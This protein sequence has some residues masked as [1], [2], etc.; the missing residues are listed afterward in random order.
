M[1][2]GGIRV[3]LSAVIFDRSSGSSKP[4]SHCGRNSAR[5]PILVRS[6]L[7]S[8]DSSLGCRKATIW[9]RPRVGKVSILQSRMSWE[10][11]VINGKVVCATGNRESGRGTAFQGGQQKP[12]Q[13]QRSRF[14]M[15]WHL[16]K[17]NH[18]CLRKLEPT[19]HAPLTLAISLAITGSQPGTSNHA[20]ANQ[21]ELSFGRL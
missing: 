19:R 4:G 6:Y 2:R 1:L 18:A 11:V 9:A 21:L 15:S 14:G 13:V 16:V 7:S 17:A 5:L 8:V 3:G 12:G 10:V 20:V